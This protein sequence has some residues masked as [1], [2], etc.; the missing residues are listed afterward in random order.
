MLPRGNEI[1]RPVPGVL[2]RSLS[3]PPGGQGS[4]QPIALLA[5]LGR[6]TRGNGPLRHQRLRLPLRPRLAWRCAQQ[7]PLRCP[8]LQRWALPRPLQQQALR[9]QQESSASLGWR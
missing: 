7:R 1:P 3:Q 9:H 2:R 6:A 8:L 5:V 4:L